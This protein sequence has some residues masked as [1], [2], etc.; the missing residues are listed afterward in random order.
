MLKNRDCLL[1]PEPA[2]T[3]S[4]ALSELGEWTGRAVPAFFGTLLAKPAR[5]HRGHD[6]IP[7]VAYPFTLILLAVTPPAGCCI[8]CK[9]RERDWVLADSDIRIRP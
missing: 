9:A 7:Q 2:K 5:V 1:C 3:T 8:L 6:A 4:P